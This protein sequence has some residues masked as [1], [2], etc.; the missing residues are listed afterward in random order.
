MKQATQFFTTYDLNLSTTL[1]CLGFAIEKI[2][3]KGNKGL[4]FFKESPQ[5]FQTIDDYFKE[6][7]LEI[8]EPNGFSKD[9]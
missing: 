3:R 6:K 9:S 7:I 4:F 2:E 5:L 8:S 1:R